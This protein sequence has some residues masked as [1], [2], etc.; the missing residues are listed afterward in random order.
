MEYGKETTKK[1]KK[2]K[3]SHDYNKSNVC[4]SNE[5]LTDINSAGLLFS[6][7]GITPDSSNCDTIKR[8]SSHGFLSRL[9]WGADKPN[10]NTKKVT[11]GPTTVAVGKPPK[12]PNHSTSTGYIRNKRH[13]V[14]ESGGS[15][16]KRNGWISQSQSYTYGVHEVQKG[17]HIPN[18][19]SSK[20]N[21]SKGQPNPYKGPMLNGKVAK[22]GQTKHVRGRSA[23]FTPTDHEKS[24]GLWMN[25]I[26][27]K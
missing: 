25:L 8:S 4:E 11:I 14:D 19:N 2:K 21:D 23:D 17:K 18:G 12:I 5:S 15:K 26:G 13:S 22:H 9:F 3:K 16:A 1:K 24:S 6:A 10:E 20:F 27:R 7:G